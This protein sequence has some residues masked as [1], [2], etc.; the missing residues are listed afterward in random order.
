MENPV[1]TFV[2]VSS[3]FLVFFILS[4][5]YLVI[6]L[7]LNDQ[8]L[9]KSE[10][11]LRVLNL[12]LEGKVEKQSQK[13]FKTESQYEALYELHRE[14]LE[15]SPAGIIKLDE[16]MSIKYANPEMHTILGNSAERYTSI[17]EM[18]IT[19]ISLFLHPGIDKF[20]AE[21]KRG[22]EISKELN[23]TAK[24]K[25][26][27]SMILTG[28]PIQV[29][30]QFTGAVLL[31]N[32]ITELKTAQEKIK[33]SL[34]EKEYLLKEINHRVKNNMQ[35]IS[36][37]LK[38]QLNYIKDPDAHR[39]SKNS[40]DRVKT[41]ALV[42][43][44]LYKSEDLTK[45]DFGDYIRSLA[46]YLFASYNIS[47]TKINLDIN[48]KN[49]YLDINTAIPCGLI[50]NELVSNALKHAFPEGRKGEIQ[51]ALN[52]KD[53]L[54]QLIVS[55]DGIGFP[56]QFNIRNSKTL[57]LQLINTLADQLHGTLDFSPQDKT[58]FTI[59]FKSIDLN[60][61]SDAKKKKEKNL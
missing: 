4:T 30:N 5:V 26:Q 34:L 55:D 25:R 2:I 3:V 52:T 11:K 6:K 21:L 37:M 13:L 44:K 28:V 12:A 42:H 53:N 24:N 20:Y 40:H 31:I 46:I 15:N 14:V 60:S 18:K 29:N 22:F 51:V 38:L 48:I 8:K 23:F 58:V 45:I 17:T 1:E 10:E 39:L 50:V 19:D 56:E 43:E 36:S 7:K 41:M 35:V 27:I 57:G 33:T 59:S 47:H 32:D 54:T 16:N 49:V 61:N 9:K